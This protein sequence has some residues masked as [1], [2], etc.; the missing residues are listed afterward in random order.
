MKVL[1]VGAT[2]ATGRLVVEQLLKREV[3]VR[4]IVRSEEKLQRLS[5]TY[6]LLEIVNASISKMSQEDLLKNVKGCDAV[7]SCLGHNLSLKGIYGKPRRL[8]TLSVK[9]LS[10]AI[11][12]LDRKKI[13]KFI[14]M[15]TTANRN[16]DADEKIGLGH[17]IF[18]GILRIILPPQADNEQAADYLRTEIGQ[19]NQ[20]MEWI[21]VRPDTLIDQDEVTSYT[22]H[23]SPIRDPVFN[24]GKTSRINVAHAM[25]ELLTDNELWDHWRGQ[26]PVIYNVED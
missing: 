1:V 24:A 18:V 25:V 26:M 15:N 22:M 10:D 2:G 3:S 23:P 4:V 16:R 6:D 11:L 5:E 14:L 20:I 7:I 12:A 13:T 19:D 8:V 17:A 21:A 9:R